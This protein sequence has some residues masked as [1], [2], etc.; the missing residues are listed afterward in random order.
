MVSRQSLA[1]SI[2]VGAVV[3][4]VGLVDPAWTAEGAFAPWENGQSTDENFFPIAVWLQNPQNAGRY[5]GIGINLYV[6]LW[7]GPTQS[8]IDT[9][10]QFDMPV[11]CHQNEWAKQHLDEALIV[12]WM[13]GDEPD[14][15][16]RFASYW[17][18]DKEKIKAGWPEIYEALN[19]DTQPYRAYGPPVPPRWIINDYQD[20]K[21]VDPIRPVLVNL[22]QGVAWEDYI[23]RGERTGKLEDYPLY[24]KGCDIVSFDI[25][26]ACHSDPAVAQKLWYVP[27]GVDRLRQ[28]AGPNKPV[29][30]C[31]E[32]TQINHPTTKATPEQIRCEVW[33]AI[34]HGAR[35][36]IYFSH[37]WKPRFIEAGLL[38]DTQ[39]AQA[40][41]AINAQITALAPV[42]NSPS[43][44]DARVRT[45]PR[46]GQ[47][48]TMVKQ[49]QD[50]LYVFAVDMKGKRARTTLQLKDIGNAQAEV[51]GEDRSIHIRGGRWT[52][53]FDPWDVHLY[54]IK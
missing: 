31:I 17:A 6:G 23:G 54:R 36:L 21:R 27:R 52:D 38:A 22:G 48:D 51:L 24:I 19:L 5:Q 10:R 25:Y 11:I 45:M 30:T 8:Q 40:V 44:E 33:M 47:I 46:G 34:I 39:T 41:R 2:L 42:I 4:S 14:N 12:A 3:L 35:G 26:P 13:H 9:L 16:H 43:L 28:W 7:Q 37:T 15:A 50:A 20:I 49:S 29:W 53:D 1:M 32:C 18:S